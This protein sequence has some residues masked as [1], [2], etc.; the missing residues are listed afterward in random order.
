MEMREKSFTIK[1]FEFFFFF[2]FLVHV[3]WETSYGWV[4]FLIFV[5]L[6]M[7]SYLFIYLK[8]K[9]PLTALIKQTTNLV[10]KFLKLL[11]NIF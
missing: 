11:S 1:Y 2:S 3:K 8:T 6:E 10:D 4:V 7:V 9:V 5:V